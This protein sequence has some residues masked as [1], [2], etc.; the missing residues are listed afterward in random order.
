M[1]QNNECR[2]PS[3][4]RHNSRFRDLLSPQEYRE[5]A[6]QCIGWVRAAV[7]ESERKLYRQLAVFWL[8][9]AVRLEP[10]SIELPVAL[11][12]ISPTVARRM[13]VTDAAAAAAQR[14]NSLNGLASSAPS[15]D[16]LNAGK[17][18][19]ADNFNGLLQ[20]NRHK[21]DLPWSPGDVRFWV[22]PAKRLLFVVLVFRWPH[23]GH[24]DCRCAAVFASDLVID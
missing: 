20:Q 5:Q 4:H 21:T 11:P 2:K 1:A 9:N 19:V 23:E 7:S 15:L 8:E 22:K 3:S 24:L 18:W 13:S 10:G 6:D 17:S 14:Q 12:A 16:H